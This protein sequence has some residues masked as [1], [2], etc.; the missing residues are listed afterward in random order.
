MAGRKRTTYHT[1]FGDKEKQQIEAL[2]ALGCHMG[3]VATI[4]QCSPDSIEK[5]YRQEYETGFSRMKMSLRRKQIELAMAGNATMLVWLGKQYLG[6]TDKQET[7]D[8]TPRPV[9]IEKLDGSETILTTEKKK[10]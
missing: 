7:V 10:S 2:G 3:E 6:Q 9:I 8:K 4:M 1:K 5:D